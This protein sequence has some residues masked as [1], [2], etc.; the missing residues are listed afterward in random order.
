MRKLSTMKDFADRAGVN[1]SSVTR[2]LQR[3][4]DAR[5]GDLLD[6]AHPA[7]VAY[8]EKKDTRARVETK[9]SPAGNP[10]AIDPIYDAAIEFCQARGTWTARAIRTEFG[11]GGERATRL[12][13]A[14][15]L[16]GIRPDKSL[17]QPRAEPKPEP[18]PEPKPKP[19]AK[20]VSPIGRTVAPT[21]YDDPTPE[22]VSDYGVDELPDDIR[23]LLQWPLIRIIK[24]FGTASGFESYLKSAKLIEDIED[25][26][27]KNYK[28]NEELISKDLVVKTIIEPLDTAFARML[29]DGSRS[30]TSILT[31]KIKAGDTFEDCEAEVTKQLSAFIKPLKKTLGRGIK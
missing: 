17:K 9:A 6:M 8:L 5:S 18:A 14:L 27:I 31:N 16:A 10:V 7:V 19:P 30:V 15:H 28:T 11:I 26:R 29:R 2:L 21:T 24:K 22:A 12:Y 4:P 20:K 13:A 1:R 25:K 3:H 23:G